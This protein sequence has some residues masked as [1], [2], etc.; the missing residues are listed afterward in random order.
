MQTVT[1]EMYVQAVAGLALARLGD[2]DRLALRGVKLTYGSGLGQGARGFTCLGAWKGEGPAPAHAF[3]EICAAGEDGGPGGWVQIAGTTLHEL[4]HALAPA[5]TGHGPGWAEA[6]ARLGLRRMK[7]AGTQYCLA[8][9]APGLRQEIAALPRP[10]DGAWAWAGAAQRPSGPR[11]CAAGQG[12]RGGALVAPGA[13][14]ASGC[15][16]ANAS[17][18]LRSAARPRGA[19]APTATFAGGRLLRQGRPRPC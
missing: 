14:R 10:N 15:T 5:G 6:C 19:C 13:V 17:P 18:R 11:P 12:T 2:V 4:G 3:I 16:T 7:A 1:R 8:L 9:F